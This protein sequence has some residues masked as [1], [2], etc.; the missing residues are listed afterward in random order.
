MYRIRSFIAMCLAV[1]GG[2]TMSIAHAQTGSISG[3]VWMDESP[4]GQYEGEPGIPNVA[5]NLFDEPMSPCSIPASGQDPFGQSRLGYYED[6]WSGGQTC[7]W[8]IIAGGL[9]DLAQ[10]FHWYWE[11]LTI[12][13][14][15]TTPACA[16]DGDD[17]DLRKRV[18]VWM[19]VRNMDTD[20]VYSTPVFVQEYEISL[21][22]IT[23]TPDND[24]SQ[25]ITYTVDVEG[26]IPLKADFDV[27]L[28]VRF[29]WWV[30][31]WNQW[32]PPDN[33]EDFSWDADAH[34]CENGGR[35][36][37]SP[38]CLL[39]REMT[40]ADGTYAFAGLDP[41]TYSVAV[42][43]WNYEADRAL[44]GLI[45]TT[46]NGG[47]EGVPITLVTGGESIV[48]NFGFASRSDV[49]TV[50]E[51][52]LAVL[53]LLVITAGSVVLARRRIGGASL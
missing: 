11:Y 7:S 47:P 39:Q 25:Y 29:Q 17:P 5:V 13:D 16:N 3:T 43:P 14:S 51:W 2:G 42:D 24:Y 52:S 35:V 22:P 1:V 49:P 21:A 45:S 12:Q 4:Y 30:C 40:D 6:D 28:M 31:P 48:Q 18:Q 50:S 8:Q 53:G 46:G 20:A 38:L 15:S 33:P 37:R 27:R 34:L 36:Y 41:S 10:Q 26:P 44:D 9:E 23:F 19:L 32:Y